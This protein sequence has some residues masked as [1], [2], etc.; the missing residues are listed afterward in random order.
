MS[1]S[2]RFA[3]AVHALTLLASEDRPLTS[4]HIAGSVNTNPV[5][6]RRVLAA[7]VAALQ[8]TVFTSSPEGFLVNS[9][10]VSGDK[11]AVLIDAGFTLADGRKVAEGI[12]ASGKNLTTVYVTH[13]H[14]DH[15]F[16]AQAIRD[17]FPK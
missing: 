14:P 2:S 9:T 16:G 10:L 4:E 12:K 5:V 1:D 15:Y 7:L 17:A 3:V 11:D 8:I 6:I 13:Y